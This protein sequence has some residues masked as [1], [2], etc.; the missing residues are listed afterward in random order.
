MS[1]EKRYRGLNE[2]SPRLAV[3]VGHVLTIFILRRK[4]GGM[5]G[6]EKEDGEEARKE[7]GY[8]LLDQARSR[9]RGRWEKGRIRACRTRTG[10]SKEG[11]ERKR[12]KERD[13]DLVSVSGKVVPG[14][15]TGTEWN[16]EGIEIETLQ[17]RVWGYTE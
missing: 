17:S 14:V 15:G 10:E 2:K 4:R 5:D 9:K 16:R 6:K 11:E 3:R 8:N 7:G 1:D 12:A 13:G